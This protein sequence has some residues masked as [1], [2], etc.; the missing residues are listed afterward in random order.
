MAAA[1]ASVAD[2]A[3]TATLGR[4][5]LY[6]LYQGTLGYSIHK[7]YFARIFHKNQQE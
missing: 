3:I 7:L 6:S 1:T 5:I 2:V 4:N